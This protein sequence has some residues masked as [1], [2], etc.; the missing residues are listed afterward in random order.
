MFL[1]GFDINSVP[2]FLFET[3]SL[4]CLFI[5]LFACLPMDT[6]VCFFAD[7]FLSALMCLCF[8]SVFSSWYF[9]FLDFCV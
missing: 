3:I 2:L 7:C 4:M 9:L 5:Y 8:L 6:F 1:C